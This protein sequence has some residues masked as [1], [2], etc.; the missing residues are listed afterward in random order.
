M[1]MSSLEAVEAVL[2]R[3]R[4]AIHADGGDVELVNVTDGVA[5]VRLSGACADC[6][7]SHMTFHVGIESAV[8]RYRP[9]LRVALVA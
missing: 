8:R 5:Y 1:D 6:P 7:M 3:I 9:E 2:N 4:P